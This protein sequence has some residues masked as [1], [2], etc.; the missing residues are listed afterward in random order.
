[1]VNIWYD[2]YEFSKAANIAAQTG[3]KLEPDLLQEIMISVQYRLLNLAYDDKD[4]HELL[5]IAMLA[6]STTILPILFSQFGAT[7]SISY[8]SL[9]SVL[10]KALNTFEQTSNE[11]LKALLWLL[12]IVGISVLDSAPTDLQLSQVIQSLS[13]SSWDEIL[14]I[15][16]D[17][18]W[19][20]ILHREQAMKLLSNNV[21][22][23]E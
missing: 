13:L 9:H 8:P 19:I 11:K 3:R 15:L 5:R 22:R 4:A 18:L 16:K 23:T 10:Q 2:L 1:M 12:V 6:Y 21:M 14:L 20:D 7:P 17:F